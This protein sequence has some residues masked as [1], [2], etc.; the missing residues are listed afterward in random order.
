MRKMYTKLPGK[1]NV[2]YTFIPYISPYTRITDITKESRMKMTA[3][4]MPGRT[5]N[6]YIGPLPEPIEVGLSWRKVPSEEW[7][8]AHPVGVE[9]DPPE[10]ADMVVEVVVMGGFVYPSKIKAPAQWDRGEFPVTMLAVTPYLE[11]KKAGDYAIAI[12]RGL[13]HEDAEAE[14][15]AKFSEAGGVEAVAPKA[16]K[17]TP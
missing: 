10:D 14:A 5:V 4:A 3:L 15:T 17:G 9:C 13:S 6:R 7:R 12:K 1:R 8:A 16:A 2:C 11:W